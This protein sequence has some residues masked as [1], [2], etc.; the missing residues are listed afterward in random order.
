MGES[1]MLAALRRIEETQKRF[2]NGMA[3]EIATIHAAIH[4]ANFS[5]LT[6]I[7]S[8]QGDPEEVAREMVKRI[9]EMYNRI[10]PAVRERLGIRP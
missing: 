10:L 5:L 7:H 1:E 2:I 9:D 3:E 8:P 6:L 4:V